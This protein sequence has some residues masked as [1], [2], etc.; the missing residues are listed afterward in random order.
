[1][2]LAILSLAALAAVAQTTISGPIKDAT[3]ANFNGTVAITLTTPSISGVNLGP[4]SRTITITNGQFC[5]TTSTCSND[6][7]LYAGTYSV[8]YKQSSSGQEWSRTWT[9]TTSAANIRDIESSA[10]ASPLSTFSYTLISGLTTGDLL[11]AA[12][13]GRATRLALGTSGYFLKAGATA[14]S[15]AALAASDV[16]SGVFAIGRMIATPTASKCVQINSA[17]TAFEAAA[18]ACGTGGGTW[19]SITGTLSSQTDLQ[20]ALDAKV[21]GASNLTTATRIMAVASAGTATE[22]TATVSGS[23]ITASLTGNASTAT[24]LAAN[25]ANCTAGQAANGVDAGGAAENCIDLAA[26]YAPLAKGVTNG[27][28][29]DH[30]GGDG[31]QIAYANVSGTPDLSGYVTSSD[32]RTFTNKTY[33]AEGTGNTLTTIERR[34]QAAAKCANGVAGPGFSLPASTTPTPTCQTGSNTLRATLDF[35]DSDGAYCVQDHFR[36]PGDWTGTI[37][38]IVRYYGVGTTGSVVWQLYDTFVADAETGDP[39]W[40]TVQ[41]VTDAAKG[42]TLQNNEATFT[43]VTTSG[44]STSAAAGELMFWKLCRDRTHASDDATGV[45]SLLGVEWTTRRAQ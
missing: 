44:S 22:S 18:A 21:A 17:G 23:T 2:R 33:D 43:S 10:P 40:N 38:M 7:A 28:S 31:A 32:S 14:P 39:G 34:W 29:H 6:F 11:Y 30:S 12:S 3:A 19:G 16:A 8:R 1:M 35:P 5:P 15:W 13:T 27:D 24:A 20:T 37:D 41:T 42:T 45:Q 25:G 36:L 9:V 4:Y 26:A